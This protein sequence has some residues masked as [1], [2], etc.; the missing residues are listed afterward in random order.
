MQEKT[1]RITKQTLSASKRRLVWRKFCL[2]RRWI[3]YGGRA[4]RVRGAAFCCRI[5]T[6]V[7]LIGLGVV[8]ELFTF[9]LGAV[10]IGLTNLRV[11]VYRARN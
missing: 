8:L 6:Q 4:L 1:F 7:S 9:F 5:H 11:V 3:G 10:P 2:G